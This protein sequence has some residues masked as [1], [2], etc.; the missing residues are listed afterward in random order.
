MV[1]EVCRGIPRGSAWILATL[2][3]VLPS[4]ASG[5]EGVE[6][7][8]EAITRR[9]L[10]RESHDP[11]SL[12]IE[13]ELTREVESFFPTDPIAFGTFVDL[14]KAYQ[15][16][17]ITANR[18]SRISELE[19]LLRYQLGD[20][21]AEKVISLI[22]RERIATDF[23]KL[24]VQSDV[25]LSLDIRSP[26]A[27]SNRLLTAAEKLLT[28][29]NVAFERV[30]LEPGVD[31]LVIANGPEVAQ[32]KVRLN[33]MAFRI[34]KIWDVDLV[35]SPRELFNTEAIGI[36]N[37]FHKQVFLSMDA[38][39]RLGTDPS[40]AHE[41]LH[42]AQILARRSG[43]TNEFS[44]MMLA[45]QP[46]KDSNPILSSYATMMDGTEIPAHSMN[47]MLEVIQLRRM[48]SLGRF[49]DE[50]DLV[51]GIGSAAERGAALVKLTVRRQR[52]AAKF[53]RMAADSNQ[54][55]EGQEYEWLEPGS[56]GAFPN[57]AYPDFVVQLPTEEAVLITIADMPALKAKM[58]LEAL[59]KK[60]AG[61]KPSPE[62]RAAQAE[63]LRMMADR[64]EAS[65]KK[66]SGL[67]AKFKKV[68]DQAQALYDTL[69][70]GK[71][72]D[73]SEIEALVKAG[74]DLRRRMGILSAVDEP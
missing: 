36:F 12:Q 53:L 26:L 10:V 30:K 63:F 9:E 21:K 20:T 7:C 18:Q 35:F 67:H 74:L 17:N 6:S 62:Y 61:K 56:A 37:E 40:T 4:P 5:S 42:M 41:F 68:E 59:A 16:K 15:A 11:V 65:S 13:L 72:A 47:L 24:A 33:R 2:L 43:K 45:N 14:H 31:A 48:H 8:V 27:Q 51:S 39:S 73:A 64:I 1:W 69:S 60:T 49:L 66:L 44:F 52:D 54:A 71:M 46:P 29:E 25:V 3:W 38:I 58:Q 70:L 32:S 19:A 57:A 23:E 34:K 55:K 50:G 28:N 22:R